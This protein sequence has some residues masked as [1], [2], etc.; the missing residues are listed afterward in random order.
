[1][2]LPEENQSPDGGTPAKK[3]KRRKGESPP[4]DIGP[5]CGQCKH[6]VAD[7]EGP[8]GE[9]YWN[10]PQ[11]NFD[12]DGCYFLSRPPLPPAERACGQFKGS[13]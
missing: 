3:L 1:M 7:K 13:N 10:P 8:D 12:E 4:V 6:W 9:C 2:P 11:V 5:T